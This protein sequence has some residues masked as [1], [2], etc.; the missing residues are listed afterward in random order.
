VF[1]ELLYFLAF[2]VLAWVLETAGAAVHPDSI[3]YAMSITRMRT[4]GNDRRMWNETPTVSE[5]TF[6]YVF[7]A[8]A[9]CDVHITA[10]MPEL[11]YRTGI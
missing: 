10:G 9:C 6:D 8:C 7:H 5:A 4:N 3:G 2:V 11:R 1:C